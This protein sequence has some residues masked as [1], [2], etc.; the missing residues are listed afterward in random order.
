MER[1]F[2]TFLQGASRATAQWYSVE[3]LSDDIPSMSSLLATPQNNMDRIF[4]LLGFGKTTKTGIFRFKQQKFEV[5]IVTFNLGNDCELTHHGVVGCQNKKWFIRVGANKLK[6]ILPPGQKGMPPR[7]HFLEDIARDFKGSVTN[8]SR[9]Q[10]SV[11]EASMRTTCQSATNQSGDDDDDDFLLVRMKVQ[12]LPILISGEHKMQVKVDLKR[13]ES[14]LFSIVR[15]MNEKRETEL[16]KILDTVRDPVSPATEKIAS[17][18]PT[19]KLYGVPL[20]DRRV[21]GGLLRDLMTLNQKFEKGPQKNLLSFPRWNGGIMNLVAVP[22]STSYELLRRY[23][24]ETK[25]VEKAWRY[26]E[27]RKER[28][29]QKQRTSAS[30]SSWC[31]R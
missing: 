1:A 30:Q 31:P 21:H 23:A 26:S 12:L 2:A 24:R 25:W 14:L 3:K 16:S 9:Q 6:T 13:L 22:R 27:F 18:C 28:K 11:P 10:N 7:I 4:E 19:L 8:F 20:E 15:E 5:F 29:D 17:F